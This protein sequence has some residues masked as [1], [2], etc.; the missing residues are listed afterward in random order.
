[1]PIPT[2]PFTTLYGSA[3]K[4]Q[5]LSKCGEA[6]HRSWY[7]RGSMRPVLNGTSDPPAPV[8]LSPTKLQ[9]HRIYCY[10]VYQ[11]RLTRPIKTDITLNSR[12]TCL[13]PATLCWATNKALHWWSIEQKIIFMHLPL[14]ET[15]GNVCFCRTETHSAWS[16]V[17]TA[18]N[19]TGTRPDSRGKHIRESMSDKAK[20]AVKEW[21]GDR[22]KEEV[23]VGRRAAYRRW[24]GGRRR[25]V[26]LNLRLTFRTGEIDEVP[27]RFTLCGERR[28]RNR[29][30]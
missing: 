23:F 26:W 10:C 19:K 11:H 4:H 14:P 7:Q 3:G 30:T 2:L 16:E 20:K 8:H 12:N 13:N 28:E 25:S 24:Q 21:A 18:E 29:N 22:A 6:L 1:M 5:Q 15:V 9:T 17:R 27:L